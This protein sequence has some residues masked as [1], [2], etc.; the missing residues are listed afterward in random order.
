MPLHTRLTELFGIE[1]P[2]I[3]APMGFVAGGKLAAAVSNAGGLGL[4]GGGY[5]DAEWLQ[6]Q[7]A[8]AGNAKSRLRLHHLVAREQARTARSG[9]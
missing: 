5:G 3:S 4:I 6:Q 7:F 9:A 8:A 2:V 1:H